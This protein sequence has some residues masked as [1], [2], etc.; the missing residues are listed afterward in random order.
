M[1][2][3]NILVLVMTCQPEAIVAA[4]MTADGTEKKTDEL[5]KDDVIIG[6]TF[7]QKALEAIVSTYGKDFFQL[8]EANGGPMLTLDQWQTKYG[9]NGLGLVAIRNMRMK[10][11]GPGVHF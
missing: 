6:V 5:T 7:N 3:V 8:R 4:W 11:A 10:L 1:A 9:T 2:S